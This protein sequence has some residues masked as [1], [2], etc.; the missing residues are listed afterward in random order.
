MLL[1]CFWLYK[2]LVEIRDEIRGAPIELR[3]DGRHEGCEESR[4]SKPAQRSR[5]ML[6]EYQHVS[7]FWMTSGSRTVQ[8][9]VQNDR[10]QPNENPGPWTQRVVRDIEPQHGRSEERRVGKD[11]DTG[12]W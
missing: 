4:D 5:K 2:A 12:E 11:G 10:D 3:R 1:R 8:I 9:W 7:V 6:R